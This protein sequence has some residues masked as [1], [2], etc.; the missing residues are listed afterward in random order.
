MLVKLDTVAFM[1]LTTLKVRVEVSVA[2]RGLPSFDIVGLPDKSVGESK[3][4]IKAAFQ[5]SKL[6]FPNKRIT[7]NLAP[8]DVHKE[9]SFYDFPIAA[10]ILCACKGLQPPKDS[11]F[12]G[13]LSLDGSLTYSRGA[14]LLALFAKEIGID[15]IFLPAPNCREANFVQD[16][17]QVLGVS[18]IKALEDHL[19]GRFKILPYT[20][21][22]KSISAA[23]AAKNV[24]KPCVDVKDI[25]G[26]QFA[27]RALQISAAGGHNLLL[28]GPPG[29]GKSLLAQ[30][31]NSIMPPL[32]DHE[33]IDVTKI[34]SFVNTLSEVALPLRT[35]PFRH[36]HHTTSYAGIIGGGTKSVPGEITLA[37]R[38]IL[39]LDELLEFNRSVLEALR[40]P[41][42][43]GRITLIRQKGSVTFPAEFLLVAA[44]NPCPCGYYGDTSHVC[45]CTPSQIQ[46]YKSK[47][48]GPLL[49]RLDLYVD[50]KPVKKQ[51][52]L[53]HAADPDKED[54]A[55]YKESVLRAREI[56]HKRFGSA[57]HIPNSKMT[58]A[59][60]AQWCSQTSEV[61]SLMEM[62]ITR[63]GL[64]ARGYF[65]VL[66]VARTIADLDCSENV[67]EAHVAEALQ[68]RVKVLELK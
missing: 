8:A 31:L 59:Q 24:E 46:R 47:L 2:A 16:C 20:G 57:A 64:S 26:Q 22:Y 18:S 9:G 50:V 43:E 10:G 42:E 4:R 35:R 32:S 44:T 54:S 37:H 21:T 66:K 40:L 58:N 28:M 6:P 61:N 53:G 19:E 41:L 7:V 51:Q 63:F 23:M 13:E 68:Y 5:N 12:F 3:H 14:F 65:K 15:S 33:S 56:Q 30:A 45:K 34:Y 49:D 29:A 48:S 25:K 67:K 39:F 27:K 11:L 38:G 1:G 52:L 36:P 55:Y 60:V 17:V 62:A